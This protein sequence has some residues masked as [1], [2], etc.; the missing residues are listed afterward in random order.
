MRQGN[1]REDITTVALGTSKDGK[2]VYQRDIWPTNKEIADVVASCLTREQF[3]KYRMK[4]FEQLD[5]NKDG[6]LTPDEYSTPMRG[7]GGLRALAQEKH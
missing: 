7:R 1:I 5:A 2:P 6:Q 4:T 3:L